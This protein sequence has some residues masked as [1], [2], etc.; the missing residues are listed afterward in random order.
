MLTLKI[1]RGTMKS[2]KS[3]FECVITVVD[4]KSGLIY[5]IPYD[6][7]LELSDNLIDISWH[8]LNQRC[9]LSMAILELRGLD[10]EVT[11]DD[12]LNFD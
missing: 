12:P 6:D 2:I 1:K 7:N 8:Y 9:L 3:K 4:K 11:N 10:I 5:A